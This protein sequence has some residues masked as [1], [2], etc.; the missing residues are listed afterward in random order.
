MGAVAAGATVAPL[1]GVLMMFELTGSYQIVLPLL[2]ACG[3][4]AAV[5]QGLLGGSIY[6]ISA[7]AR[8]VILSQDG[9]SLRELSVAQALDPVSPIAADLSLEDLS[10][11]VTSTQHAAFPVLDRGA[12]AGVLSV[13]A[14]RDA[15]LDPGLDRA[16]TAVTFAHRADALLPDD[17]LGIAVQRLAEAGRSEALVVDSEGRP[18]GVVTREGILEAWRRATVPG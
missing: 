18:L 15:L 3:A 2:I 8:G 17:D 1:T 13:R 5:V 14:V 4:A 11:L 10:R 12:I 6:T 16:A 9:V 7:R